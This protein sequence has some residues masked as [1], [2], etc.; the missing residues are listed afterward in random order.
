M[1][2]VYFIGQFELNYSSLLDESSDVLFCAN[3]CFG[4]R[5]AEF[6]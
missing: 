1:F 4:D 2:P 5:L 6:S 3:F